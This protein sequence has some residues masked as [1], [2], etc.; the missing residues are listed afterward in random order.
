MRFKQTHPDPLWLKLSP[1][2]RALHRGT[3]HLSKHFGGYCIDVIFLKGRRRSLVPPVSLT[4]RA[5][6]FEHKPLIKFMHKY[7]TTFKVVFSC[8]DFKPE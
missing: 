3:E 7:C 2:V 1:E 4:L 5:F 6:C 8:L